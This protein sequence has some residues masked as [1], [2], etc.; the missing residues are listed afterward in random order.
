MEEN[1]GLETEAFW[2]GPFGDEYSDRNDTPE[3]LQSNERLFRKA[4]MPLHFHTIERIIEFGA[5][6]GP[7]I[8]ALKQIA[9]YAHAKFAAVELNAK[10]ADTLER[11]HPDVTVYRQSMT[12]GNRPWGDG[13]DLAISKG[14]LIHIEPSL[15]PMAYDALYRASKKWI[16]I[17]EYHNPTPVE[18][19]Y[20]GHTGRLWKRDF[21]ADMLERYPGMK[22][23]DYGFAWKHDKRGSQDDLVHT[24]LEKPGVKTD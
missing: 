11:R 20:R 4:L 19:P 23:L 5:N 22:V 24:L 10:A 15:L 13:Y 21:A 6:S 14:V 9:P 18:V 2:Q 8:S 16:F 1:L 12:T 17:A 3:Q 7:N